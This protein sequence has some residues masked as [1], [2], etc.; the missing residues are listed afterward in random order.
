MREQM[1]FY[2]VFLSQVLLISF[3][4]PRTILS[5]VRYVVETYPPSK[6]PKLYPVPIE[7]VEKAQRNYRNMNFVALLAG[8][9]LLFIG[10]YS[11]TEEM[12]NWDSISVLTIYFLVQHSPMMIAASSGFTYFNFMRRADSRTT[13]KAELH[14]RRLFDFVSPVTIGTAIF[15]Y[16][17]FVGFIIYIRQFEF[18]WFGGYWN[19][20][21]ITAVNLFFAGIIAQNLYGKKKDPYQAY[22][23]RITY[24]ELN[25]KIL[26][27]LS[28]MG[29][30]FVATAIALH[31]LDLQDLTPISISLFFQL[32][33]IIGFRAF[34]IDNI[35]FEVYKE[36]PLVA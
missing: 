30:L 22:E 7:A 14:P 25:V 23:D 17:A 2:F 33:A 3:Y 20:F 35:N 18:S 34:R 31:A 5:R 32:M 24:I 28:I 4:L 26:V 16:V 27:F 8:L 15:V 21:G 1:I 11:P 6:Y 29:P 10:L 9:V 13:R 36:D 12:L 19:I